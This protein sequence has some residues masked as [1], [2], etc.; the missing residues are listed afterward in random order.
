MN[1][2][3]YTVSRSP[4]DAVNS[5]SL[6]HQYRDKDLGAALRRGNVFDTPD[7]AHDRLAELIAQSK[8][9]GECEPGHECGRCRD[10][11]PQ[12]YEVVIKTT[13][14]SRETVKET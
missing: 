13:V 10:W 3:K 2:H 8:K 14:V 5:A 9:D 7:A 11:P 4:E 6:A 1:L 12:V